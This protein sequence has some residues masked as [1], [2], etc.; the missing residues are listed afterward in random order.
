[1]RR[2]RSP[3]GKRRRLAV[4]GIFALSVAVTAP[5]LAPNAGAVVANPG[6]LDVA[7]NLTV[8]TPSFTVAGMRTTGLGAATMEKNG[9]ITIPKSSLTF[10]PVVVPIDLPQPPPDPANPTPSPGPAPTTATVRAVATSDFS[11]GL[12]PGN[13][14]AFIVGDIE[15]VWTQTGTMTSCIVGP[16]HVAARTNARGGR[17]YQVK[18][19]TVSMVDP[20][21]TVD[22]V[23][24]SAPGCG[25]LE[26][27]VNRALSLPVTTTTTTTNPLASTT[28]TTIPPNA[29]PPVPSVAVS[30]TFMPAPRSVSLP[31]VQR[32]H[33]PQTTSAS[34]GTTTHSPTYTPPTVI[35]IHQPHPSGS[36]SHQPHRARSSGH[37]T[38]NHNSYSST[39]RTKRRIGAGWSTSRTPRRPTRSATTHPRVHRNVAKP[40]RNAGAAAGAGTQ[41]LNFTNAAFIKRPQSALTT[42]LDVI[43]LL[44]LLGFSTL[45]LWLVTTELSEFSRVSRRLRTHRIAGISK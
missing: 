34:P 30:L 18:T 11:G 5:L 23:P 19:G 28:T 17:G 12:D 25:G 33:P 21:F 16:F 29:D 6:V 39:Y 4:A 24:V 42:G 2:R 1:M 13:G 31:P 7:M 8:S 26:G 37:S 43:G 27:S 14:A 15:E 36:P 35:Y 9:L 20:D 38:Y 44:G 32:P 10:D 22:A 40:Q 45:A 3:N 41:T